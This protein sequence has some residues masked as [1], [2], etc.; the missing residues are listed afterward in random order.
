MC[1][2][3]R[4]LVGQGDAV[5]AGRQPGLMS[6]QDIEGQEENYCHW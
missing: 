1:E 3:S 2:A 4:T 6:S 5:L